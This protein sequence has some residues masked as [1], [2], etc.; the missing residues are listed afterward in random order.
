MQGSLGHELSFAVQDRTREGT[1][2]LR[3]VEKFIR[4][5]NEKCCRCM[6]DTGLRS[7][8]EREKERERERERREKGEET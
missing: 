5:R 3:R 7:E 6:V 1:W 2:T 8:A 4:N